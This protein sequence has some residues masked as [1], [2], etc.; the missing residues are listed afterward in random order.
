MSKLPIS[1]L[2]SFSFTAESAE[3]FNFNFFSAFSAVNRLSHDASLVSAKVPGGAGCTTN[4]GSVSLLSAAI[5][6]F[7]PALKGLE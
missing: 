4:N 7:N 1:V 2:R 5:A 3:F 6:L